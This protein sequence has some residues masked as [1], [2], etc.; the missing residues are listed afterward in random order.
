MAKKKKEK[1]AESSPYAGIP[2]G[3]ES[4]YAIKYRDE[5]APAMMKKFEYS[6]TMQIPRIQ[7]IVLNMGVG[8]ASKDIKLLESASAE[9]AKISGQKARINR[10][11]KSVAQFKLREGMPIG[12][13]VTLRGQRMFDFLDRLV[14][15]AIP[16]VRDFRGLPTSAFDGR[17]N[18]SIGIKEQLI[19]TEI[20]YNDVENLRGMNITTVTSAKTDTECREMLKMFGM[21]FRKDK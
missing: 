16:R 20:D 4:R 9:I 12:C 14:N 1:K 5:V 2:V 6:S 11:T 3:Y 10:A 17:G 15:V 21:P 8:E 18:H 19:F 7:K 13:S